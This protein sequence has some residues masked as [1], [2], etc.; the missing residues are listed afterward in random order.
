MLRV[1]VT[2]GIGAGKS[3][4]C[5]V[6]EALGVPIYTADERAKWLLNHD[7]ALKA[8]VRQLLGSEAYLPDG[9]YHRNWVASQ[10]FQNPDLLQQ[11]NALVHPRVKEDTIAW[12]NQHS[13]KP[14]I[15]KEAAIMDKPNAQ[16]QLDC[17]VVVHA[18]VA[19]R[20]ARVRQRDPHR[21][22][23]E[24][25]DIIARQQPDTDRLAIADYIV[26]NDETQLLLPQIW[27][28]HQKFINLKY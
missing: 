11:L 8:A 9:Q 17:V 22:E 20:V 7:L 26:Y 6:F 28:L 2:G 27:L 25:L 13:L 3:L 24:I 12:V 15:I 16:N 18:P 14:Y 4:V 21:S 19:L 10:V 23:K 1:G 5:R